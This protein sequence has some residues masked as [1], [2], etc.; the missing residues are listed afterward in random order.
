MTYYFFIGLEKGSKVWWLDN[1]GW[2]LRFVKANRIIRG[3]RAIT[4]QPRQDLE[5]G[6]SIVTN[7]DNL[8]FNL[9]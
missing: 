9:L 2:T 4:L 3:K 1:G 8:R 5:L 6:V 7:P